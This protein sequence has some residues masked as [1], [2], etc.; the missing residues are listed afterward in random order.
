MKSFL[1]LFILVSF[2]ATAQQLKLSKATK[3]TINGGAFPSSSA[4][5]CI[6]IKKEKAFA[7]SVDS[8]VDVY[9][10]RSVKFHIVKV[11]NADVLSPN[12]YTQ[13]KTYS[14]KDK[15]NYQLTFS[16][17]TTRKTGPDT[18]MNKMVPVNDVTQGVIIYYS[19]KKKG[20]QLKVESFDKL[21]TIDAP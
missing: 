15:G 16:M 8:V 20:K 21:E 1:F 9:T 17:N 11:D 5:Y 12:S 13:V 18:P 7:W 19:A 2:S 10:Q 14:K 3:Q 6:F 4:N